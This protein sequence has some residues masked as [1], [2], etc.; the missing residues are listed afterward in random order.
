MPDSRLFW[1]DG[2]ATVKL[3]ETFLVLLLECGGRFKQPNANDR[4]Y[5]TKK[6]RGII[7]W[8]SL[9]QKVKAILGEQPVMYF[10]HV[11]LAD[12]ARRW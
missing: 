7:R 5:G 4:G 11:S 12:A 6:S 3:L 2:T 1:T 8:S 10:V 9:D